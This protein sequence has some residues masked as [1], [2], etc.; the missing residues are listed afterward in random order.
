VPRGTTSN[1]FRSRD[2][3]LEAT[4][5]RLMD[6]HFALMKEHLAGSEGRAALIESLSAILEQALTEHP[7]RYLAML[8]LALEATR[9]IAGV[10]NEAM[11]L[12]YEVH[13]A[14][15]AIPAKDVQALS[16]FYNGLLFTWTVMPQILAGR[17]PGEITREVLEKLLSAD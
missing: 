6:L 7:G 4:T 16:V 13:G 5:R 15:E 10:I 9:G 11:T 1:Y 12:T 14:E 3:L 17:S 2:A 8:E